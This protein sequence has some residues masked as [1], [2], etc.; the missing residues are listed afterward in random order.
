MS[1]S[2]TIEEA[3]ARMVNV[4]YIPSGVALIDFL[5]ATVS[6]AEE[7]LADAKENN[8]SSEQ[9]KLLQSRFDAAENRF[10]LAGELIYQIEWELDRPGYSSLLKKASESSSIVRLEVDSVGDWAAQHYAFGRLDYEELKDT[11]TEKPVKNAEK[12]ATKIARVGLTAKL[13]MRWLILF[14]HVLEALVEAKKNPTGFGTPENINILQNAESLRCRIVKF[15]NNEK[16]FDIEIIK[17]RLETA[18]AM[19]KLFGKK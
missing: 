10:K 16:F 9:I 8:M 4:E 19:K 7:K 1:N 18:I 5:D 17:S 11:F 3:V 2:I 15:K 12:E 13:A 6:Q 14:A